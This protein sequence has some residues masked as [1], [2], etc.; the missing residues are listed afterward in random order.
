MLAASN[1]PATSL[2]LYMQHDAP[3]DR[4]FHD[5]VLCAGGN[6]IRLRSRSSVGGASTFPDSTD[7]TNVSTRGLVTPGS[8]ATRFY[9]A[10]YRN[11]STTFASYFARYASI[12][13]RIS[14]FAAAR[15]CSSVSTRS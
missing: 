15:A 2:A 12:T 4:V 7:T 11:A 13:S 8:G 9:A 1:M 14:F 5:G 3:D 6:L 10:W